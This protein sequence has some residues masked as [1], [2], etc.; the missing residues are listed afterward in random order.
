VAFTVMVVVQLV[1]AFNCRSDRF[2]LSQLGIGTN[3]PLLWAF[4][5]PVPCS[6]SPCWRFPLPRPSS[7]SRYCR[8]KTG[9]WWERWV[10]WPFVVMEAVKWQRRRGVL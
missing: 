2:S 6:R 4:L 7:R 9:C 5:F 3:R 1:Q 10:P 8:S